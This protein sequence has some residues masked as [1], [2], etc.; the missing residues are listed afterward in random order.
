MDFEEM[1]YVNIMCVY[2]LGYFYWI[3]CY[4]V[5]VIFWIFWNYVKL[6]VKGRIYE[7]LLL[8]KEMIY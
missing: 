4:N 3:I 1:D 5:V 2:Y 7:F 8:C 6:V